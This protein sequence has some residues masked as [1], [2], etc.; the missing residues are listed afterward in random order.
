MQISTPLH[1]H[2]FYMSNDDGPIHHCDL[3]NKPWFHSLLPP[4][5]PPQPLRIAQG[6]DKR[7]PDRTFGGQSGVILLGRHRRIRI[8]QNLKDCLSLPVIR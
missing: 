8:C 1:V 3:N 7:L 6:I 4:S 2:T 5:V